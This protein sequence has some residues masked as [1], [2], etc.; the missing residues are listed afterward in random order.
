M[1]GVEI[2]R[3][4]GSADDPRLNI[5]FVHGLGSGARS[6][7]AFEQRSS[8]R[9]W[10]PLLTWFRQTNAFGNVESR[11]VLIPLPRLAR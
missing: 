5:V 9:S 7:W 11:T 10:L 6:A 4:A 1:R 3:V 8:G 2:E